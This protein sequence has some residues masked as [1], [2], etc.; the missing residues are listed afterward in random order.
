MSYRHGI[1]HQVMASYTR[2]IDR[3][4]E[5]YLEP[6]LTWSDAYNVRRGNPAL[7]PEYIDSYELG[8]QKQIGRANLFSAE[9]Y[10]R[11]AHNKIQRVRSVYEENVILHTIDNVGTDYTF[12]TEFMLT[13]D[14]LKWWNVNVMGNIY[15]YR[16]EGELLGDSFDRK[17][18]NWR[19]QLNN[20][21]KLGRMTRIQANA[22]Y[23]SPT[24]S[25]QG[26]REGYFSTSAAI[27]QDF[28]NKTL[29]VSL[30]ARDLFSK[31]RY[32]FTSEGSDFY[33]YSRFARTAPMVTLTVSYYLNNY[34]PERER[35]RDRENFEGEEEF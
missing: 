32:E 31:V 8:Y 16:I 19:A 10:Y 9:V 25:S 2:R 12:G 17:S 3:P 24:V 30:Q 5:W 18:T 28:M 33:S 22:M 1:G 13:V 20:T 23:N 4:R 26:R 21:F 11:V 6:F 27:K 29:S 14:Q 15:N 35:R 7:K 34:K